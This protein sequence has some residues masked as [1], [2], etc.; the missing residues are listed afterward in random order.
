ML[1]NSY[2]FLNMKSG[3]VCYRGLSRSWPF[4]SYP[5]IALVSDLL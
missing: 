2:N 1:F 4:V 3:I 5:C